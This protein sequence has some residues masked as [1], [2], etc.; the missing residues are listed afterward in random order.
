M[1]YIFLTSCPWGRWGGIRFAVC[2]SERR[3]FLGIARSKVR[4]ELKSHEFWVFLSFG[5]RLYSKRNNK[6]RGERGGERETPYL[7]THD[8]TSLLLKNS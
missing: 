4:E 5:V 6:E 8:E 3:L 1:E 7:K 2:G